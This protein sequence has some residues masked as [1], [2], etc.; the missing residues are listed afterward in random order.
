MIVAKYSCGSGGFRDMTL[1]FKSHTTLLLHD[2]DVAVRVDNIRP[3]THAVD[4]TFTRLVL[5]QLTP[6]DRIAL[7]QESL[8]DAMEG[9][10]Q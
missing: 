7:L 3:S 8:M 10:G 2:L 1:H 6:S 4:M 5:A 9:G